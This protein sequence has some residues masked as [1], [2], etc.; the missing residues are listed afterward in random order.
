MTLPSTA[1]DL[2]PPRW[3]TPAQSRRTPSR[4]GAGWT[5]SRPAN[6]K[7]SSAACASRCCAA[8]APRRLARP[9]PS[10]RT[11]SGAQAKRHGSAATVEASR[12]RLGAGGTAERVTATRYK[13]GTRTLASMRNLPLD[14]P[15]GDQPLR[16]S[17]TE[18]LR[19]SPPMFRWPWLDRLSRVHPVVPPLIFVPAIAVL[20]V[21]RA[22]PAQSLG[23]T[24]LGAAR[25]LRALDLQR[26]LDSPRDLPLRARG[27][28]RRA[29]A[30]DGA[31]R[32]SRPPQRSAAPG[33]AARRVGAAGRA[34]PGRCSSRSSARRWRWAV[35][36][37]FLAGY[38]VYDMLH[39]A[40]HH[41][42]QPRTALERRLRELHMRHHFEDDNPRLRHQRAVVGH[43]LSAPTASAARAPERRRQ[44]PPRD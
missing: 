5:N 38:L 37:G 39:Y 31:R 43:R 14:S 6:A 18:L 44:A 21:A 26:V 2:I 17:R 35:G 36:A 20:T 23:H 7:R 29:A 33:D 25:R 40:L 11:R 1:R 27:R 16:G 19:A 8:Q 41:H 15:L 32:P 10:V 22:R 24:L 13:G 4:P 12:V 3:I 9:S 30:L 42:R 34:V 28:H